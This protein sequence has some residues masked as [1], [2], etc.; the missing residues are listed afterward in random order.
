MIEDSQQVDGPVAGLR[1][2]LRP[3]WGLLVALLTVV[4]AVGYVGFVA[5]QV[6][7]LGVDE[8][9]HI[10]HAERLRQGHLASHDDVMSPGMTSAWRCERY[11][12]LGS[13]ADPGYPIGSR[14]ECLSAEFI[15][16]FDLQ[17]PSHQAQHTPIYYLPLALSAKVVDKV[18]NLDPFVDTYRVAGLIFTVLTVGS[19][20]WLARALKVS[21]WVAAAGAL[22]IV[23]ASN[24]TMSH[25]FIN[26]DALAIPGGVALLL[27]ARR[28]LSNRSP[29]LLLFPVAFA[30][31]LAKPTF[32][33]AH[34]ATVLY[35]L[36]AL[37][38][39]DLR[40]RDLTR[41]STKA[42]WSKQVRSTAGR[43]RP[44]FFVGA[45]LVAATIAFQLWLQF[46]VRGTRSEFASFYKS[47]LFQA[48]FLKGALNSLHNPLSLEGPVSWIDPSY[49]LVAMS[50]LE[51]AMFVGTIVV[52]LGLYRKG[53]R[54][55]TLLGRSAVGAMYLG[56][57]LLFATAA[58][59][60]G[61][62]LSTNTRYLLPVVPFMFGA[63][64]LTTDDLWN[65]F[66][67][68]LPK[69]TLAG[70][71]ILAL[72][73]QA[74]AIDATPNPR[75]NNSWTRR[76][77]GVV[78]S[79]VNEDLAKPGGCVEPGD[80]VMTIP[81]MPMLYQMAPGIR[82]PDRADAYWEP[83][84]SQKSHQEAFKDLA[85]SDVDVVIVTD[86][87]RIGYERTAAARVVAEWTG[88]AAW[89]PQD[90]GPVH[91]PYQVFVRP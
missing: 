18:T 37:E 2:L 70:V 19:L 84:M 7:G 88:C 61:A 89:Q 62:V 30:V 41:T 23:G 17:S 31:A 60:G 4:F 42:Q 76:Q 81:Y 16:E 56:S 57:L 13:T 15:S 66:V 80:T 91:R 58:A 33:A 38:P 77:A 27:T 63:V 65:R 36:Q 10:T 43:L 5:L 73:V 21:P 24:F 22:A 45:G 32:I 50:V 55:A 82:R 26:N 14:K 34:V 44:T 47:R 29:A 69:A 67:P 74:V 87:L 78:A 40:W 48:D 53:R 59:R 51:A 90:L 68:R 86:Y 39:S 12:L 79:F 49:G 72:G 64:M 11:R 35:L 52:A 71:V 75:N 8:S 3:R 6:P 1:Y 25:A 46:A 54:D 20:L 85:D 83:T 28:V 9:A